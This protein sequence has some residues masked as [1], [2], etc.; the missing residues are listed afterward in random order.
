VWGAREVGLW[1]VSLTS[2]APAGGFT[3]DPKTYGFQG[4][5]GTVLTFKHILVA[6]V[7]LMRYGFIYD[8]VNKKIVP[9]DATDS[10]DDASGD[11]LSGIALDVLVISE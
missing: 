1:R 5:V 6:N 9:T 3:F 8:Y 11:D 4:V 7:A 10:Y 2:S